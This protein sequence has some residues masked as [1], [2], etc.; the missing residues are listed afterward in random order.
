[1]T[2]PPPGG[3]CSK[4]V[5]LLVDYLE[6][7]LAPA[8]LAELDEH[9]GACEQCVAYL[10]TYRSTVSLLRSL[11]DDDLPTELRDTVRIFL[12]QKPIH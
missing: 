8:I 7:R 6:G 9:L 10:N 5:N 4:T 1:M 2:D 3:G 11:D 12:E